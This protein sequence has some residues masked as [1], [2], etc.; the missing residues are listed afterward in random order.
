MFYVQIFQSRPLEYSG[1]QG[2]LI[3]MI[4]CVFDCTD[5]KINYFA[6]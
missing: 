4:N 2:E 3:T 6:T 1:S 5:L